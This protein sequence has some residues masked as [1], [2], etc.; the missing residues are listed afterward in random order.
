MK[1]SRLMERAR[2]SRHNEALL[3]PELRGT[4]TTERRAVGVTCAPIK[5]QDAATQAAIEA[6]E[7]RRRG[8]P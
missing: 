5:V 3:R 8:T 1:H 4:T 6:F 2:Q 7:N